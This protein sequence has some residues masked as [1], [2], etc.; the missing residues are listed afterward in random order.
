MREQAIWG[1]LSS[2]RQGA[3]RLGEPRPGGSK[4]LGVG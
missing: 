1:D 4:V 2:E 3:E